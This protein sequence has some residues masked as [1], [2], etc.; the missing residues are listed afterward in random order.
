MRWRGLDAAV[1][2]VFTQIL[3]TKIDLRFSSGEEVSA[4]QTSAGDFAHPGLFHTVPAEAV[5]TLQ[6]HWG[7][8]NGQADGAV[9][10]LGC[11]QGLLLVWLLFVS[12][13]LGSFYPALL[14]V[15]VYD[16]WE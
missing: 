12:L 2:V 8:K 16:C 1:C 5:T 11:L 14:C 7:L 9:Q 6:D 13:R 4:E 10:I 3:Q 15:S